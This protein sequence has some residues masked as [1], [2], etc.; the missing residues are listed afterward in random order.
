AHLVDEGADAIAQPDVLTWDHLVAANDALRPAEV[1][2]DVAVLDTLYRAV[3]RVAD[4]ILEF[5]ELP[6]ALGFAHLLNDDLFGIL[7][8]DAAEFERR[9]RFGEHVADLRIGIALF[10]VLDGDLRRVVFDDI[11]DGEHARQ[12]GF[13]GFRIDLAADVVLRAVA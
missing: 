12:L 2:D 11:D 9:Q 6:V 13:A 1:D 4:T 8:S 5:G 3:S 7:R 10:G